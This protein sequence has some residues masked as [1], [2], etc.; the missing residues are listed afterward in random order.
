MVEISYN[1][2]SV[3]GAQPRSL[4]IH[5]MKHDVIDE[6]VHPNTQ[7]PIQ[8]KQLSP[9]RE[10]LKQRA[11]QVLMKRQLLTTSEIETRIEE[12]RLRRDH[13]SQEALIRRTEPKMRR[14]QMQHARQTYLSEMARKRHEHEEQK[15][16]EYQRNIQRIRER[17]ASLHSTIAEVD[18]QSEQES[19][20]SSGQGGLAMLAQMNGDLEALIRNVYAKIVEEQK[21]A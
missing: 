17:E 8:S 6:N 2:Q 9:L 10:K 13:A 1:K 4:H 18:Q 7:Q 20:F 3:Y 12:A 19:L 11:D 5:W 21:R 15:V 14:S 16:N